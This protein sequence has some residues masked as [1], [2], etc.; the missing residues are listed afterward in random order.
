MIY[1]IEKDQELTTILN[2]KLKRLAIEN[3][4]LICGDI[5]K[6]DISRMADAYTPLNI[7]GNLPFNISSPLLEKLIHNRAK[8]GRAVLMF[9]E[10][11]AKRILATPGSK[12]YGAIT[13]WLRYHANIRSLVKV[14][15]KA[16]YPVPKVG[17][18]VLEMDFKSPHPV[19]APD[20]VI[21]RKVIKSAFLHRRKTLLNALSAG[22]PEIPINELKSILK[23]CAIDPKKRAEELAIDDYIHITSQIIR[24]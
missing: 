24:L 15:P 6:M 11:F 2:E 7:I 23:N 5:L 19:K 16:Y 20:E 3:V 14:P 18:M 4:Y 21:M 12:A 10:E 1:A 17:G 9:Q 22:M 13:V 8:L